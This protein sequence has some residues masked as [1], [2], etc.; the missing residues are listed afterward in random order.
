MKFWLKLSLLA[1]VTLAAMANGELVRQSRAAEAMSGAVVLM[2]HRFGEDSIPSTNIRLEQFEQHLT[3]LTSGNYNVVT[4]EHVVEA[5]QQRRQLPKN[6]VAITIDDAYV[7]IYREAWPRLRAAG[8][9]FTVFVSTDPIDR[10]AAVYMSWTQLKELAASGATIAN[11]TASH[12]GMSSADDAVN[13]AEL[14]RAQQR[15]AD[16]IGVAS[17]LFAYPFGE[18]SLKT[19]KIVEQEGFT[20]AFGQHS[21]VAHADT[22]RF[23]LPRFALNETY[24]D[25]GRFRL[26]VNALP[27]PV[28]EVTPADTL[29]IDNNPPP[30]GFTVDP[31]VEGL[32]RLSCFASNGPTTTERLGLRRFEVRIAQ[33]FSRGRGRFNCTLPTRG[34][35]FRWFGIQFV[36]P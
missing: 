9:P 8:L 14:T 22:H 13:R 27:L 7:S 3:E 26:V 32:E 25:I 18:Y 6:T 4:L 24:G 11:H 17:K 23:K 15:I 21:G 34:G 35:R 30:F 5:F 16:E 20:A 29:L 28:S 36:I 2:Y 33:P 31:R 10:G 19:V 12:L 1:F